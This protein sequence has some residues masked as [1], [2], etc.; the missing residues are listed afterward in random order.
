MRAVVGDQAELI[1][2]D[3]EAHAAYAD[4]NYNSLLWRVYKSHRQ[5]L[6]ELPERDP[7]RHDQPGHRGRGGFWVP[8][9]ALDQPP[10]LARPRSAQTARSLVGP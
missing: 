9:L 6:F 2:Q 8:A 1:I 7:A 5:T 4:D 10:R 3:C